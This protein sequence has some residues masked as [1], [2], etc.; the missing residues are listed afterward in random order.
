M[1][2]RMASWQVFLWLSW[3]KSGGKKP[4]KQQ[5]GAAPAVSVAAPCPNGQLTL[6]ELDQFQ[7]VV[8]PS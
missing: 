1:S 3:E 2:K 6:A 7:A 4:P 5:K 8:S